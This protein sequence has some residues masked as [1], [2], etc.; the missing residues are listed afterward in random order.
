M[1]KYGNIKYSLT[2]KHRTS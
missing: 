1:N 2:A